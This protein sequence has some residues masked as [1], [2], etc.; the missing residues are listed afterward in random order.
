MGSTDK[1]DTF[2]GTPYY[3]SPEILQSK[4]THRVFLC[5]FGVVK[6]ISLMLLL[7]CLVGY[8]S[9]SDVW[10]L[11][12]VLYELCCLKHAFQGEEDAGGLLGIM[13]RICEGQAPELPEDVSPLFKILICR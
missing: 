6:A 10:S 3:M 1:A 8:N 7:Y 5:F 12:C 4:G 9:K 13:Y 11:G 2:A